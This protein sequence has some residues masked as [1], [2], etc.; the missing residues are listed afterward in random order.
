MSGGAAVF[1]KT[2]GLTPL[3]TRLAAGTNPAF[4]ENWY[5]RAAMAV[6]EVLRE[7]AGL[8]P[9]WAVAE[10]AEECADAWPDLPLLE[11]G[12]GELGTRMGR[13]HG[14]LVARHGCGLLL[15]ADTPQLDPAVLR[16]ALDWLASDAPRFVIGP[17][18]DG[19]FWLLG[20]NRQPPQS[21]WSAAPC[22]RPDTARGFR[23][24]MAR[25]GAWRELPT[26]TDVDCADDLGPML[27]ELDA[28]PAPG[29]AQCS[30]SRWTRDQLRASR[31]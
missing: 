3:K 2:P 20:G 24:V 16:E 28:L 13:V 4:A 31:T 25:H 7:V 9:Y 23:T 14:M 29:P 22:G 1:V 11:Q 30:L 10:H 8:E 21:D 26:L 18:H 12:P 15:G 19:G 17:A 5:R 6:A 27:I